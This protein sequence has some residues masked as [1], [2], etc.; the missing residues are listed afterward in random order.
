MFTLIVKRKHRSVKRRPDCCEDKNR[1]LKS[2]HVFLKMQ[3]R[4]VSNNFLF[5]FFLCLFF[6]VDVSISIFIC[7]WLFFAYHISF[8]LHKIYLK[9]KT[10]KKCLKPTHFFNCLFIV[11]YV[12][13]AKT[14]INENFTEMDSNRH[15]YVKD[16]N[17]LHPNTLIGIHFY[18]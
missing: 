2:R 10:E 1:H 15:L 11:Y 13:K 9:K 8:S 12:N 7:L 3:R 6:Y 16:T 5:L 18:F 17:R 14:L 4:K